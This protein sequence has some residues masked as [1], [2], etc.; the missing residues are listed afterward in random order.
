MGSLYWV[1]TLS[2][3]DCGK[4][5]K[6]FVNIF[7]PTCLQDRKLP[8]RVKQLVS[9]EFFYIE[10]LTKS[11]K[12]KNIFD[13][14]CIQ[15]WINLAILKRK[16]GCTFQYWCRISENEHVCPLE[17]WSGAPGIHFRL[18]SVFFLTKVFCFNTLPH[19]TPRKF[20]MVTR[21]SSVY[22]QPGFG[23]GLSQDW[24]TNPGKH[25]DGEQKYP[26]CWG[27]AMGE[28]FLQDSGDTWRPNPQGSLSLSASAGN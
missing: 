23:Q 15:R 8:T 14:I 28:G 12:L 27:G 20:R 11:V 16:V 26:L 25:T 21:N 3:T 5:F 2:I 24:G 13:R 1:K 9:T 4:F 10:N 6:T 19:V 18:S 22:F 7:L 17:I